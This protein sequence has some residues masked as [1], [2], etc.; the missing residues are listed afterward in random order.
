[1]QK[2]YSPVRIK[3]PTNKNC[4]IKLL[5]GQ[6][7]NVIFD[8]DE[9]QDYKLDITGNL[10]SVDEVSEIQ[11]GWMATIVQETEKI[12]F[13]ENTLFLGAI[14]LFNS[15]HVHSASLCVVTNNDN[16]D[17]LRIINPANNCC[18]L[19]PNQVLDVVFHTNDFNLKWV[20]Y[21][22]GVNLCIEQIQYVVKPPKKYTDHLY[23]HFFRFRYNSHSIKY[24]S[25]QPF[26]KYEGGHIFFTSS[27]NEKVI[28]K[29]T[30]SWRGK[31]SV[32][33]ALLMP[34][35]PPPCSNFNLF[36]KFKKQAMQS[37]VKL[38]RIDDDNLEMGCNIV[39]SR[40]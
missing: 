10:L 13:T 12:D 2:N 1:M 15:T 8:K 11:N 22:S 4:M 26:G 19:E 25:E 27:R 20:A 39:V 29:L 7:L 5:T 35:I 24:I 18:N 21:P 32:Y 30:C 40:I 36:R 17:A 23:E 9:F 31:D 14:N 33:K 38:I 3:N 37:D 6:K 28:I 16:D 34:K